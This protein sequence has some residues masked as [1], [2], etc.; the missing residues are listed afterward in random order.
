MFRVQSAIDDG[1]GAALA[2]SVND[3]VLASAKT[4]S[5]AFPD[6]K[7]VCLGTCL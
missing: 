3:L 7:K 1:L 2:L 5:D 4:M 6:L